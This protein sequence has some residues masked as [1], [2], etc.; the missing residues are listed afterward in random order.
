[1]KSC[2]LV[3]GFNVND[4]G[5]D[6]IDRL[7]PFI[8]AN[9]WQVRQFDYGWTGLL[10]TLLGNSGR[11]RTL[12]HLSIAGDI[13]IGHSNGCAIIHRATHQGAGFD[14]VVYINPALDV[15]VAPGPKVKRC[16]VFHSPDDRAVFVAKLIPGVLWG[17]MG[18][19]GY[20]GEPDDRIMNINLRELLGARVGHSGAFCVKHLYA[21]AQTLTNQIGT[22][23][24]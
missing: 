19:Y 22:P 7:A 20:Q 5:K 10:M 17:A 16:V 3:H 11:A 6:T 2:Y 24:A 15:D 8:D 1:M 21:F 13:A 23:D 14:T 9:G 12:A 18:R 4:D